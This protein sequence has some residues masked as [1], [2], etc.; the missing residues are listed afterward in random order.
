M[1]NAT[2]RRKTTRCAFLTLV[3]LRCTFSLCFSLCW[4]LVCM[5]VPTMS[6][7]GFLSLIMAIVIVCRCVM[8]AESPIFLMWL[9]Q[10]RAISRAGLYLELQG[11]HTADLPTRKEHTVN[12]FA[13][14]TAAGPDLV[15]VRVCFALFSFLRRFAA[16]PV[17]CAALSRLCSRSL[18]LMLAL[19][20]GFV[21]VYGLPNTTQ[22]ESKEESKV[23]TRSLTGYSFVPSAGAA[24][25]VSFG[26]FSLLP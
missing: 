26:L 11:K 17:S 2:R 24:H 7:H 5:Y 4:G 22:A 3:A 9:A 14:L 8:S 13:F 6:I 10:F 12:F 1:Q 25:E 18:C 23:G 20:R 21:M 16:L 19:P 15:S